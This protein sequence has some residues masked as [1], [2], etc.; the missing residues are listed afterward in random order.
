LW[1]RAAVMLGPPSVLFSWV[2]LL[3]ADFNCRATYAYAT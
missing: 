2:N 3:S 1:F